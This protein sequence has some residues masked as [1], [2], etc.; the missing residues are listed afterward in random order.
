[1]NALRRRIRQFVRSDRLRR[2]LC[3]AIHLYI[4]FVYRTNRWSIEGA[5]HPRRLREDGKPF[6]LA[7][8]HGRLLMIPMAWRRLAPIHMLISSHRDGRIIA[9]A[10]KHFGVQSVAGSTRRGGSAALRTMVR[11]LAA[12]DCV[13]ITP[14]GPA[15]PPMIASAGIVNVARL[16]RVPIVPIVFAA[17][18]RF[19]MPSWDRM[20]I[21]LPFGRGVF[22]WGEPIELAGEL[23]EAGIEHARRLVEERMVDMAVL[24]D[25]RVGRGPAPAARPGIDGST[26]VAAGERR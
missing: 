13:G 15:G 6:I 7:F 8:W 24:A 16:A 2:V 9:D 14:D 5:E 18:R 3:Y 19:L 10:V 12:G 22:I 17:S 25:S 11:A 23:D 26:P 21:A 1:M 4:R 20:Q